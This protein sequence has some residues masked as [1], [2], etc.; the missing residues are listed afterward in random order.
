VT[1]LVVQNGEGHPFPGGLKEIIIS[2]DH[3]DCDVAFNDK[4]IQA[5]GGLKAMGWGTVFDDDARVLKHYCSGHNP[6]IPREGRE[7]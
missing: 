5:N 2:C 6:T 7:L 1:S 3:E 4:E